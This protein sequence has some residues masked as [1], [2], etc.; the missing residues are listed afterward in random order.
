M[1]HRVRT[2]ARSLRLWCV[3]LLTLCAQSAVPAAART[4][5]SQPLS[6]DD[7]RGALVAQEG[8]SARGLT[9]DSAPRTLRLDELAPGEASPGVATVTFTAGTPRATVDALV[10][11]LGATVVLAVPA[12]DA[13]KVALPNGWTI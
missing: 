8:A 11:S 10:A 2:Q 3:L 5:D 4:L 9:Y 7:A 1:V 12:L 6:L 13:Y